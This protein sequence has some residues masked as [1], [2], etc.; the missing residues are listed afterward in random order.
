M[1]TERFP[2]HLDP[3]NFWAAGYVLPFLLL[4]GLWLLLWPTASN[5]P[6]TRRLRIFT[7]VAVA[8]ALIGT[9]ISLVGLYNPAAAAGWMRFYWYRLADVAVPVGLALMAVRWLLLRKMRL[10]LALAIA[11]TVFHVADCVVM[12]LFAD[13][14]FLDHPVDG[15]AWRSAYLWAT[16]RPQ[17][18][19][20]PL[21]PRADKWVIYG[22]WLDV[23]LWISDPQHTPPNARFLT[24]RSALT[25]KWYAQRGEVVTE[26]EAPQDAAN[27]VA[28]WKRIVDVYAIG[29]QPAL[30]KFYLALAKQYEADYLLTRVSLPLLPLPVEHK[31]ASYVVYRLRP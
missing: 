10:A 5:S 11:V 24:P 13:P 19:L 31:N 27:L 16:G 6:A 23:C 20:F 14:P 8:I 4:V 7:A 28:W 17:R 18:P 26:K 1:S 9:A 25:F 3:A 15:T 30:D 21:V 22:D 12:R 29:D 2:H